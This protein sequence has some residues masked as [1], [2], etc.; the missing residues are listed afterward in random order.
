MT[1]LAVSRRRLDPIGRYV[2]ARSQGPQICRLPGQSTMDPCT[3]SVCD[4]AT[5]DPLH[6]CLHAGG[7]NEAN[8][9][10]YDLHPSPLSPMSLSCNPS[11]PCPAG[12]CCSLGGHRVLSSITLPRHTR[13]E[14]R[15]LARLHLVRMRINSPPATRP[16]RCLVLLPTLSQTRSQTGTRTAKE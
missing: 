7:T 10:R 3:E 15:I 5:L 12:S 13:I 11:H 8:G 4:V 1:L 14:P 2:Q 16:G 6:S 9:W